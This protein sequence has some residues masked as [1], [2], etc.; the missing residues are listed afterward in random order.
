MP[1]NISVVYLGFQPHFH[2]TPWWAHDVN[3]RGKNV[4]THPLGC[5]YPTHTSLGHFDQ[6]QPDIAAFSLKISDR[7]GHLH[8]PPFKFSSVKTHKPKSYK[9]AL[10]NPQFE[11]TQFSSE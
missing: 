8:M 7:G 1:L 3:A 9:N 10:F 6:M 4:M 2:I 5:N 11:K